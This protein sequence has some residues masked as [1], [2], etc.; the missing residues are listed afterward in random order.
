MTTLI[1]GGLGFIGLHTA[2]HLLD[3]GEDVVLTQYKVDRRPDFIKEEFGKRAFVEQLDVTDN[4]KL[5]DIGKRYKISGIIHLATPGLGA[6]DAAGDYRVNM[7]GLINIMEAAR[8][9]EVRRLGLASSVTVYSGESQGP[10]EETAKLRM[11]PGNPVE[12]YKKA[13][14]VLANHFAT[15]TG[16]EVVNLRI[17][18]IYGPLYHSMANLPSRLVH[19][20]LKG[21]APDF[22]GQDV[23]ADDATDM[24]YVKDC[25]QGIA[26]LQMA[27]N[28]EHRTY[29]VGLGKATTNSELVAAIKKEFPDAKIELKPGESAA[30]RKDA[31]MDISRLQKDAG[32]K[33]EFPAESAIPDYICWLRA[34]NPQ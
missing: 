1:T 33:P 10:F 6:L 13:F 14:E 20:A 7:D 16:I 25:G 15:R 26:L 31:Y 18:G 21:E 8:V 28:L 32:Y 9:W 23:Y 27:P 17:A 3:Q 19:A 4:E 11:E 5:L 2:R 30:A 24:C 12:A 29:N 22:R 34:G